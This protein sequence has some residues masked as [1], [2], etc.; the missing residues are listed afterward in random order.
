MEGLAQHQGLSCRIPSPSRGP[1]ATGKHQTVSLGCP[2][3]DHSQ[4]CEIKPGGRREGGKGR[5][6]RVIADGRGGREGPLGWEA[7]LERAVRREMCSCL[8]GKE[9]FVFVCC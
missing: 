1:A 2:S 9:R 8:P 6:W 3:L 7:R 5:R 4:K